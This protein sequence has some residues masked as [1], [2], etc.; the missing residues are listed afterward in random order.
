MQTDK[1]KIEETRIRI[2]KALESIADQIYKEQPKEIRSKIKEK[3]KDL[4]AQ[5][6]YEN[7][8]TIEIFDQKATS[9][10]QFLTTAP[11]QDRDKDRGR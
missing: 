1:D 8:L 5:K 4:I 9:Q 2:N 6:Q 3:A 11:K 7:N 10:Q